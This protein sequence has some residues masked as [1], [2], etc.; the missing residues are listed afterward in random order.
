MNILELKKMK[1]TM[2]LMI[3]VMFFWLSKPI[4]YLK[5]FDIFNFLKP[6]KVLVHTALYPLDDLQ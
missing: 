5:K 3:G 6:F 2:V 1:K 4:E